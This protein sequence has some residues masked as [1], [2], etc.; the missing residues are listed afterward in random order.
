MTSAPIHLVVAV[1]RGSGRAL[2]RPPPSQRTAAGAVAARIAG[3]CA[4][5]R[6]S[7]AS[8]P[9]SSSSRP[10]RRPSAPRV[11]D[12]RTLLSRLAPLK[13][14]VVCLCPVPLGRGRTSWAGGG[15]DA[16]AV[17]K[18][19]RYAERYA[20]G[21]AVTD[22]HLTSARPVAPSSGYGEEG[23]GGREERRRFVAE[24]VPTF[25]G[26]GECGHRGTAWHHEW[27][28]ALVL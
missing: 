19:Y 17:G 11:L 25:R 15:D 24:V 2:L 12:E 23:G 4:R 26:D 1:S 7:T 28:R 21:A 14:R 16:A 5:Y 6:S 20:I 13:K 22:P 3:R 8:K 27:G 18:K 10:S 9:P